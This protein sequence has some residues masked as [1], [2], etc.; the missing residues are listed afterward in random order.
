[1]TEKLEW[2]VGGDGG[3]GGGGGG[4]DDRSFILKG[5]MTDLARE[6]G[7][8]KTGRLMEGNRNP[9]EKDDYGGKRFV[10]LCIT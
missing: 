7:R 9:D 10:I 5:G 4:G 1:M 3:G 2:E 8:G 6:L